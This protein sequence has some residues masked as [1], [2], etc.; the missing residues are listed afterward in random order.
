MDRSKILGHAAWDALQRLVRERLAHK[1]GSH[2][3]E[4]DLEGIELR[5]ALGLREGDAEELTS[6]LV[7]AIDE[8]LDDAVERAAAFRPGHAWCHRCERADCEHSLPPSSRHVFVGYA[9]T[10]MPRFEDFSQRCLDLKHPEVDRLFDQPP[11]LL[12]L[13]EERARLEQGIIAAF[14][15]RSYEL[16]G[17]VT[18]GFFTAAD[19]PADRRAVIAVTFQAGAWRFRHGRIRVGLNVLGR[20]PRGEALD[21]LPDRM[22]QRAVRWAQAAL[23]TLEAPPRR[24]PPTGQIERLEPR[25]LAILR[26]LAR[27]LEH[28]HRARGRRTRHAEERHASGE[29][30]TRK[31]VDDARAA[32]DRAVMVDERRGTF[33]VLG[34]R[35]RTHFFTPAGQH[36][37]SVRYSRE[38]VERKIQHERWRAASAEEAAALRERIAE[39]AISL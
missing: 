8:L 39:T 3:I 26:G 6:A 31:A 5:I 37:S 1:P 2:L 11:R 17:Q 19:G 4:A 25:V 29:R 18:A 21:V 38:A 22:W 28:D 7:S 20:T 13:V 36:V 9:Q 12:T 14:R 16:L 10:G 32:P 24:S 15:N 34:E 30:P 33:V 23:R 27:R 35:G